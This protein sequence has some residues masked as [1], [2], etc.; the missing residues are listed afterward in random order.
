MQILKVIK[1]EFNDF[2]NINVW[3]LSGHEVNSQEPISVLFT[4]SE[5]QKN[6]ITKIIFQ[7]K[8]EAV[9]LGVYSIISLLFLIKK[10]QYKPFL[11]IIEG[12]YLHRLFFKKNKDFFIPLWLTSAIN[13]PLIPTNGSTKDDFRIIIKSKLSYHVAN[14]VE[15]Y[16]FFYYSMYLPTV[17]IRHQN[18]KIIMEYSDMLDEILNH[19]GKLLLIKKEEGYISGVII[20][21]REEIPRIW[22][23]GILR[24]DTSLWKIGAITS[25]YWFSAQYLYEKGF[26]KMNLGLT[27]SFLSDGILQYKKKWGAEFAPKSKRGFIIR[28]NN[29]NESSSFFLKKNPFAYLKNNHLYGAIFIDENT[30]ESESIKKYKSMYL[31]KSFKKCHFFQFNS[32]T[33][34]VKKTDLI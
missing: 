27:R 25:T 9:F 11:I 24:G 5:I 17:E 18:R 14:S 20:V 3:I 31:L 29:Y 33:T 6:Y 7:S 32:N 30:L 16:H 10:P 23:N 12:N 2:L 34:I 4:G 15:E 26:T 22:S 1:K 28:I 8:N 13:I 19:G 21:T